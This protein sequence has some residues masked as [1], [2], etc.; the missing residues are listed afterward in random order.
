MN[1]TIILI[2]GILLLYL[3]ASGKLSRVLAV[4]AN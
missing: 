4:V 2:V 3:A 1:T